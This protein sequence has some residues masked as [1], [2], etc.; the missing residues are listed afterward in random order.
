[1]GGFGGM[2]GG[3]PGGFGGEEEEALAKKLPRVARN[4]V[5]RLLTSNGK[6]RIRGRM[7]EYRSFTFISLIP[8]PFNL[9]L[10]QHF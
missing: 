1:M 9:P 5:A 7:S 2:P 6:T 3:M 10:C 4:P 8:F